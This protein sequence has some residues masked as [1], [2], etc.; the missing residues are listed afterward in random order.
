MVAWRLRRVPELSM[1]SKLWLLWTKYWYLAAYA[2]RIP[3]RRQFRFNNRVYRCDSFI[4]PGFLALHLADLYD[5]LRAMNLLGKSGLT[6]VD[7]GAHHGETVLGLHL[8]LDRPTIYAFEPNPACW[9]ILRRN[10]EGVPVALFNVGLGDRNGRAAFNLDDRFS[11]WHTFAY[12]EQAP[13]RSVAAEIRR[14]DDIIDLP[15]IDLLKIDVEGFEY[16]VLCGLVETMA[17]CRYLMIEVSL[18]RPKAYRFDQIAELF[19]RFGCEIVRAG[20]GSGG[21]PAHPTCIDLCLQVHHGA[22]RTSE[23]GH[24]FTMVP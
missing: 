1:R 9:D 16:Q 23:Q 12:G 5:S 19:S 22:P 4:D 10:T 3:T 15:Q 21:D 17:H 6:V 7:V 8:M 18:E 20:L 24:L 2:L 11:G 13:R 14:G